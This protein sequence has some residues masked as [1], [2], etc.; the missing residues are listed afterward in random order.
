MKNL[1]LNNQ[2]TKRTKIKRLPK[3]GFYDRQTINGILD[4]SIVCN[5]GFIIDNQP[6]IIPVSFGRKDNEI[7]FHGAKGSRMFKMLKT[8]VE[9]CIT[10]TIMDGIVLARSAFHHSMNYR[11]VVMFGKTEEIDKQDE[12]TEALKNI[13]D[14]IIPGRWDEVRKPNEKELNMTS[15]FRFKI[16][17]ASAKIR[18]GSP[19]DEKEDYDLNVWAGVLP[20]KIITDDPIRD[21]LQKENID[22]PLYIKNLNKK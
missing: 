13:L 2:V 18:S 16:N 4:E 11:S 3:R 12:K 8:G 9:I 6:F 10:V 21:P 7:F 15:V 20:L 5:I 1:N 22:I 14:H 19:V 17:E